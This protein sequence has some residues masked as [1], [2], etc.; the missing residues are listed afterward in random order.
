MKET[1]REHVKKLLAAGVSCELT[2]RVTGWSD[3]ELDSL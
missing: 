3:V 2:K 1:R